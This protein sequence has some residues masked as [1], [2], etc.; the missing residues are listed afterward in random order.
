MAYKFSMLLSL[1]FLVFAF[2]LAGD[3]TIVSSIRS[4]LDNLALTISYRLARD[5]DLSAD[6]L[7]LIDS[8]GSFEERKEVKICRN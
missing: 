8:F 7:D 5:G 3:I 6:A 4:E 1:V 2:L